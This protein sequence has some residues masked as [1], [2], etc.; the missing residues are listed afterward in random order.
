MLLSVFCS[1]Q[2]GASSPGPASS[3]SSTSPGPSSNSSIRS[4][5][6][7]GSR[8][9]DI[10]NRSSPSVGSQSQRGSAGVAS[11]GLRGGADG[12]AAPWEAVPRQI[13]R[14]ADRLVNSLVAQS[15][16]LPPS[17]ARWRHQQR[18]TGRPNESS[19]KAGAWNFLG[20]VGLEDGEQE[21]NNRPAR[22]PVKLKD[23]VAGMLEA[24]REKMAWSANLE[25]E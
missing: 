10:D 21:D 6:S 13:P 1:L 24:E 9:R 8:P 17:A 5:L 3:S 23:R 25:D 16:D 15:L 7:S 14:M 4:P 22:E 18:A 19:H 12:V 20:V 11:P 2:P